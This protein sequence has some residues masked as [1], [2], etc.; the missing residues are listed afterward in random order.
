MSSIFML[1][2]TP[3][4]TGVIIFK[5]VPL[6]TVYVVDENAKALSGCIALE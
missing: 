3:P 6:E 4:A 5:R 2:P 1:P